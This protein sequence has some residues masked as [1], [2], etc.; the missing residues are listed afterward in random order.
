[1]TAMTALE[2]GPEFFNAW[3]QGRPR[4]RADMRRGWTWLQPYV[5]IQRK[6]TR[7]TRR[8]AGLIASVLLVALVAWRLFTR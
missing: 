7:W 3:T 2:R 8:N 6:I 4:H 5:A 1:M